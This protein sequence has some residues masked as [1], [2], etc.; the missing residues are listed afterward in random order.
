MFAETGDTEHDRRRLPGRGRA[1]RLGRAAARRHAEG[2]RRHR[3]GQGAR[4][5]RPGARLVRQR[6]LPRQEDRPARP[7]T[8]ARRCTS[9]ST[10]STRSGPST[11][12]GHWTRSTPTP[13]ALIAQGR[14]PEATGD[15]AIKEPAP[16]TPLTH[17]DGDNELTGIHVSDGSTGFDGILGAERPRTPARCSPW[18]IF[19]TGQHGANI[20]YEIVAT[21]NHRVARVGDRS[22][23]APAPARRAALAASSSHLLLTGCGGGSHAGAAPSAPRRR[24]RLPGRHRPRAPA[25]QRLPPRP[26]PAGGDVADE[27]TTR[28]TSASRCRPGCSAGVALR[29]GG[30]APSGGG[31]P[32]RGAATCAGRPSTAARSARA[33]TCVRHARRSASRPAPRR[34][35]P[36]H[37]DATIRTYAEDPL[38]ALV[39]AR[40]GRRDAE[41][42]R[43]S[44]ASR[45]GARRRGARRRAAAA[46]G[47]QRHQPA[48]RS[49]TRKRSTV[50]G[51]VARVTPADY[52]QPIAA[53]QRYVR[54]QLTRL[55]GEVAGVRAAR[56]P[57]H[58]LAGARAR[59]AGGRRPL[60]VDRRR[61]RRLR[62]PRRRVNGRPAASRAASA[63]PDFTGLHRIELA[64][65]QR[66]STRAAA[67]PAAQ[68]ARDVAAPARGASARMEIDPLEYSLR[69]H[70]VLEDALHLQ[71]SGQASPWSGAALVAA[72]RGGRA[73]RG[74]CSRTLA[75]MIARRDTGGA[76][77]QARRALTRLAA[78]LARP[79]SAPRR[80]AALGRAGPARPRARRRPRRRRPPSSSPTC[81]S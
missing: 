67:A 15:I 11:S 60:R 14:D 32:G 7:R 41:A 47:G 66:R 20:T 22:S 54:R 75:P 70:E 48:R 13:S 63:H 19:V 72:A 44:S 56:S 58:D 61:L 30:G 23:E 29:L 52:A 33:M 49:P 51:A 28:W 25:R 77:P 31:A 17:N 42:A 80:A 76:L 50:P 35:A 3:D 16:P 43:R 57:R 53:Y 1:R 12:P 24:G 26:L 9:S 5:R 36:V 2:R 55:L 68:L 71:L 18:R 79:A 8:A 4:R 40:R 37:Y 45:R 38:N 59:V 69:A 46:P 27:R 65:W 6:H 81:P 74:S 73:G 21:K 78:A 10:P 39:S 64:L 62:R 34:A